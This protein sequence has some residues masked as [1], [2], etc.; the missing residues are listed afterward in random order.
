MHVPQTHT[1]TH[2]DTSRDR[3]IAVGMHAHGL[4]HLDQHDLAASST[5]P[6]L[7]KF[8]Q[9][10]AREKEKKKREELMAMRSS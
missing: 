5:F 6:R 1:Q 10:E 9:E 3:Y 8:P 2:V 7:I 4:T